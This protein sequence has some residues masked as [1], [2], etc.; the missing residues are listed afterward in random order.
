[1][2]GNSRA[3]C[4]LFSLL[5][6]PVPAQAPELKPET[7]LEW[8]RIGATVSLVQDLP[9]AAHPRV[10]PE[11]AVAADSDLQSNDSIESVAVSR[12]SSLGRSARPTKTQELDSLSEWNLCRNLSSLSALVSDRELIK[13]QN[14]CLSKKQ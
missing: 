4:T 13:M 7:L 12:F 5:V 2:F 6:A 11:V 3:V 1:M 8:K 10:P 14:D 9:S